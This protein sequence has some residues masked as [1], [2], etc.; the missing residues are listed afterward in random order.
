MSD[1]RPA[2]WDI[3]SVAGEPLSLTLTFVDDTEE[4]DP[5][6]GISACVV[7]ITS[8]DGLTL[9]EIATTAEQS[10]GVWSANWSDSQITDVG[11][12][13]WRW[14]ATITIDGSEQTAL[15]GTL[16]LAR[17]ALAGVA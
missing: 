9:L 2:Q 12:G 16:Q 13:T 3:R 8:L 7:G 17:P 6:T 15:A 11:H 4:E 14:F 10:T 1:R 5:V